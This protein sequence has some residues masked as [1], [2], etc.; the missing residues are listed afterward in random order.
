MSRTLGCVGV[1]VDAKPEAVEYYRAFGSEQIEV[2]EGMLGERPQPITMFLSVQS[3]P[4]PRR[5]RP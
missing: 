3:I 1:V 5:D 4:V 2:L